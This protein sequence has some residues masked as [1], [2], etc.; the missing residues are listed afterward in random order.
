[1]SVP[2]RTFHVITRS[3]PGLPAG[4]GGGGG[5]GGGVT[6]PATRV[7]ESILKPPLSIPSVMIWL[8]APSVTLTLTVVHVCQPPVAG[9]LTGVHTL[10]AAL[11]PRC[12]DPPP[13]GAATRSCAER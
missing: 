9:M 8:P 13:L 5:G 10:L 1:M 3:V 7:M 11:N 12:S 4:G 2:L 6:E